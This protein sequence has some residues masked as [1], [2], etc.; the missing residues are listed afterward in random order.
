MLHQKQIAQMSTFLPIEATSTRDS[1]D[2]NMTKTALLG[3]DAS[4]L[5]QTLQ[6][7]VD[8]IRALLHCGICIRPLY[9]P[10]TLGCGHTFCYSC[11]TSWFAG[12]RSNKTCPDCRAPVKTQ[13]APAYL[14]RAVV[15]LFT[16][17]AELLEKGETT[18]EHTYHQREEAERLEKDKKNP[19]PKE[20]GLFRGTFNKKPAQQ[21][22]VDLED[23]VVRCPRCSWE[24]EE[25]SNC[26]QC[27]YRQDEESITDGSDDLS[28][29]DEDSL[30]SEYPLD[31]DELDEFEDGFEDGFEAGFR[32]LDQAGWN[33]YYDG[34]PIEAL[35][36][37]LPHQLYGLHRPNHRLIPPPR[38][39]FALNGRYNGRSLTDHDSEEEE[40]YSD[41][42]DMDSFIDD[43]EHIDETQH[44]GSE[45]D[46]STVVGGHEGSTQDHDEQL[47]SEITMS[48]ATDFTEDALEGSDVVPDSEDDAEGGEEEDEE[49]D[50]EPI[51]PPV[52]G[53][54]RRP[55]FGIS[56]PPVRSSRF[57]SRQP[58]PSTVN[59]YPPRRP[60][61]QMARSQSPST[62]G[63]SVSNAISLDDDS[64]EGPIRPFRRNCR[65][66]AH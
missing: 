66:H 41:D 34:V 7:H 10:F 25:D 15:Q 53:N 38:L 26:V 37:D 54:R 49:D 17:R 16:G 45:S 24:L 14:V 51:R 33:N 65:H 63:T 2:A 43:D 55:I 61:A 21:P 32:D 60:I 9:E 3:N 52:N 40:D 58:R 1:A 5:S 13:P 42:T 31:T 27:G 18:A 39:P 4:G 50:D 20:G 12:G 59:P 64:D 62:E 35:T 47:N 22:I 8:D 48:H 46:R 11:L 6:G 36:F 29:S 23:N 56:N 19:D 28:E 30:M 57:S 44:Y